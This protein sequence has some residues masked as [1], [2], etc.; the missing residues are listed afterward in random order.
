MNTKKAT[1]LIIMSLFLL[2]TITAISAA[3][4]STQTVTDTASTQDTPT[5]TIDH[6]TSTT[7]S[8]SSSTSNNPDTTSSSTQL[9]TDTHSSD[10]DTS[11][12]Q[13]S[14]TNAKT[15]SDTS[16]TSSNLEKTSSEIDKTITNTPTSNNTDNQISSINNTESSSNNNTQ[17]AS[18]TTTKSEDTISTETS[19]NDVNTINSDVKDT[20]NTITSVSSNIV[21]EKT[22][23]KTAVS[24]DGNTYTVSSYSDLVSAMNTISGL[25][26]GTYTIHFS[27]SSDVTYQIT[28]E[29][30][31]WSSNSGVSLIIDGQDHVTLDGQGKYRFLYSLSSSTI[32]IQNIKFTNCYNSSSSLGGGAILNYGTLTVINCTFTNNYAYREGGAI[33]NRGT[34]TVTNCTFKD[35]EA[36]YGGAIFNYYHVT[37]TITNSTFEG[38]TVGTYSYGGAICNSGGY[39]TIRNCTFKGNDHVI[40]TSSTGITIENCT[41]TDNT[42]HC[43]SD[44]T[45]GDPSTTTI[46]NCTFTGNTGTYILYTYTSTLIIDNS[47]FTNNEVTNGVIYIAQTTEITG[48]NFTENN[49]E[50][51]SAIHIDGYTKTTITSSKFT[52]NTAQN[53]GAIYNRGNSLTL[54]DSTFE[55]NTATENGGAIYNNGS[56]LTVT[57]CNF[58]KNTAQYGGAICNG[59][60]TITNS[61]LKENTAE[62]GGAMYLNGTSDISYTNITE[63]VATE[64][65][66]ALYI[67]GTSYINYTNI[68]ENTA[69]NGGAIY[70]T[71][72]SEIN[73]TNMSKNTAK[74]DGGAIYI[75][76]GDLTIDTCLFESNYATE[77]GGA[78]Y[79]NGKLEVK[80]STFTDNTA[81]KNGGAIY[82]N[83]ESSTITG[84]T[85]TNNLGAEG[86]TIYSTTEADINTNTITRE[87]M[88]RF[89]G[90][91]VTIDSPIIGY[92]IS[93]NDISFTITTPSGLIV[94]SPS[95]RTDAL[96]YT[97]YTLEE[98][99]VYKVNI[100]YKYLENII[101]FEINVPQ[102]V[103]EINPIGTKKPT[104]D[105]TIS[106]TLLYEDEPLI[107][108]IYVDIYVNDEYIDTVKV[109]EDDGTFSYSYKAVEG[110]NIVKV[111]FEGSED[112]PEASD[113][114]EFL[115][116]KDQTTLSL[117]PIEDI[118]FGNE[119]TITFELLNSTEEAITD[120]IFKIEINGEEITETPEY[121]ED[122]GKYV[123]TYT[124]TSVGD[125]TVTVSFDGNAMYESASHESRLF[126]VNAIKTSISI[127]PIDKIYPTDRII[128]SGEVTYTDDD[129]I[130]HEV[131]TGSVSLYVDGEFVS[132]TTVSDVDGSYSFDLQ[133]TIYETT[134]EG[135]IVVKIGSNKI[136]VVYNP[137]ESSGF[138]S[139]TN[140]KN[141]EV[142]KN[143]PNIYAGDHERQDSVYTEEK[144]TGILYDEN[145]EILT[146]KIINYTINGKSDEDYYVI[147]DDVSGEFTIYF[148]DD[149]AET[150]YIL[151]I[152][153][154]DEKYSAA[155]Y[156]IS[157]EFDKIDSEITFDDDQ[158]HETTYGESISIHGDLVDD[159]DHKL[160]NTAVYLTD[161]NGETYYMTYTDE[162]GHYV[163]NYQPT[164]A[165]TITLKLSYDGDDTA[166][167]RAENEI[168]IT[169]YKAT[170][171]LTLDSVNDVKINESI[172][173]TGNL[174]SDSVSLVGE[175]V[176]ITITDEN[177][178]EVET[179]NAI[180]TST[181]FTY[182]TSLKEAGEY[183]VTVY[184]EGNDNYAES[185]KAPGTFEV[186]KLS[187]TIIAQNSYTTTV[188]NTVT[189]TGELVDENDKLLKDVTVNLQ[190][191]NGN[192]IDTSVTVEHGVFTVEYTTTAL[193]EVKLQ[194]VSAENDYYTESETVDVTINVEV[195]NTILT[196]NSID[197]I[198]VGNT[199]TIEGSV[200]GSDG[201]IPVGKHVSIT[202]TTPDGNTITDTAEIQ[203]D[204]SY[205]YNSEALTVTGSYDVSVTF[206]DEDELYTEETVQ[207][208]FVVNKHET[209]IEL[210]TINPLVYGEDVTISGTVY[211]ENNQI[212][213]S[214]SV[215]IV[216]SDGK[217]ETV[218]I[219]DNKFSYTYTPSSI[220]LSTVE[221]TFNDD[222]DY[223]TSSSNQTTF[224]LEK[225]TT[226]IDIKYGDVV[227]NEPVEITATLT[228]A[229]GS[230]IANSEVTIMVNGKEL[231]NVQTDNNG[232][233]TAT[234][235][236]TSQGT[237]T[238]EV[239]YDGNN[240]YYGTTGFDTIE[241]TQK[242]A[243]L[244]VEAEDTTVNKE[245]TI[246][247]KLTT[248]IDG[249]DTAI[250]GETIIVKVNGVEI[251]TTDP[252][253]TNDNGEYSVQYKPTTTGTY[254]IEAIYEGSV[255]YTDSNSENTFTVTDI[256]TEISVT[257]EPAKLNPTDDIKISGEVTYLDD[258]EQK[259]TTG[260]VTLYVDGNEISTIPVSS[261]DGSYEFTFTTTTINA[262]NC[263]QVLIGDNKVQVVYNPA[264]DS[265][266]ASSSNDATFNVDKNQ[267][268]IDISDYSDHEKINENGY[269]NGYLLD[270]SEAGIEGATI[271]WTINGES[272]DSYTTTTTT[273]GEFTI[274]FSDSISEDDII[275]IRY[276]GDEKYSS[277]INYVISHVDKI[278][279]VFDPDS[280][281]KTETS[282][283]SAITISGV[284]KDEYDNLL[285]NTRVTLTDGQTYQIAYTDGNGVYTF[286]YTPTTT[287]DVIL[288]I[289]YAGDENVHEPNSYTLTITVDQAETSIKLDKIENVAIN[290]TLVISGT[291]T[292]GDTIL[293]G[294]TVTVTVK[295]ENGNE[296][297]SK[298]VNVGSDGFTLETVAPENAGTYTVTVT[299]D[300]NDNYKG[301]TE[302]GSLEVTKLS[303][304]ISTQETYTTIAGNTVTIT[305]ELY[306][307]NNNLVVGGTVNL[308]LGD[309]V[310]DSDTTDEHGEFTL[311]YK[312]SSITTET[313][314]I[315][316]IE[317]NNFF[318]TD[319]TI[320]VV[321]EAI[322]TEV[323]IDEISVESKDKVT[324]TGTLTANNEVLNGQTVEIYI[325]DKK[326]DDVTIE[327]GIYT[328]TTNESVFGNNKVEVIFVAT[329]NYAGSSTTD[330][331]TVIDTTAKT[332]SLV[333][334]NSIANITIGETI[335]ITGTLKD[336]NG[337]NIESGTVTVIING[338]SRTT[339]VSN[340]AYKINGYKPQNTGT[341][342]VTVVYNG[343]DIYN[344]STASTKFNVEKL[345]TSVTLDN[346]NNIKINESVT[347]T[348][349]L[350]DNNG[351]L[352]NKEVIITINSETF[353]TRTD[354]N[355]K[356]SLI[357]TPSKTGAYSVL[358][359]YLEIANSTESHVTTAFYTEKLETTITVDNITAKHGETINLTAHVVDENNNPVSEGKVA[360]KLNDVTLKDENGEV[361]YVDVVDGVA[362][363][364]YEITNSAKNYTITGLYYGSDNYY[365][366]KS[367]YAI[368]EV[369]KANMTTTVLVDDITAEYGDTIELVAQIIDEEGN[370]VTTG[371]VVFK[372][373]G[374][375]LKDENGEVIYVDVDEDGY[376]RLEY[377][378]TNN[379]KVYN[380][381]AV[382]SGDG[383]YI[384]SRNTTAKLTV[385]DRVINMTVDS[386]SG[387]SGETVKLKATVTENNSELV[388]EGVVVFKLN[389]VTI[390]DESGESIK[391][392]V[393]NGVAE[394]D[395]EIP[396]DMA[397]KDYTLTAVYSNKNYDRIEVNN[398]LTVKRSKVNTSISPLTTTQGSDTTI[399]AVL[400]DENGNQIER[401]TKVAIKING[402]TVV[403]TTTENGVL[404][405]KIPTDELSKGD[406]TID[407]VFGENSAYDEL[408]LNTTLTIV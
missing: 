176:T 196:I 113:Q 237:Y 103:L 391:V 305:G 9:T 70:I 83:S 110:V 42:N 372:L 258:T 52:D 89:V 131:T 231:D 397:G 387:K 35:N 167:N 274:T 291:L 97:I 197:S 234:F 217:T 384:T 84:N 313:L 22:Q 179:D 328:I 276:D 399:T 53:G 361:I 363:L 251:V 352:A 279:A 320:T 246:T 101:N 309:K 198:T 215:T 401:S 175:S 248:N 82:I 285:T 376:A 67:T 330:H 160:A 157:L 21:D 348:G 292:S 13:S 87:N 181:G 354:E 287:D 333:S 263:L 314:K 25:S 162:N 324:I 315:V 188:G 240:Y 50:S 125:K 171:T 122:I 364:P 289:S 358:V 98:G 20:N 2:T 102:T 241:V 58:T 16:T 144:I 268:K 111:V 165:D 321:T 112:Y 374:V 24:V 64:N 283:G 200:K 32:T 115:G 280:D 260:T 150:D 26:S 71:G 318:S 143:Q 139:S 57:N 124:P 335:D 408:R 366:D 133:S 18:N 327:N 282:V 294:E 91:D 4:N 407:V 288:T 233:F 370:I 177:D 378:I 218:N 153:E 278:E 270:E 59:T 187:T 266:Y 193:G 368:L 43:L 45:T 362:V 307:Q 341:Y 1:L 135:K 36:H 277:A 262:E 195:I 199:V 207:S 396:V 191:E 404:N 310:V 93:E 367:D 69:E 76:N 300:G 33:N 222:N 205:K 296:V 41:F 27:T 212:V 299:Y 48:C 381:T 406:Y 349:V 96:I 337:N 172:I 267:A 223:Y 117:D 46:N 119:V 395:Y 245:T 142:V 331:Y 155:Y 286:S 329:G 272:D 39:A 148:E 60:L 104:E 161:D 202:I 281:Q 134:E 216:I 11:S 293:T 40:F 334:V 56:S 254:T 303:T 147:T 3:D 243:K 392:N 375:S 185:E 389:G 388:N 114:V 405:V 214:G 256:K 382:Y 244:T 225:C 74:A 140:D 92:G 10:T 186:S 174:I 390:R 166:H 37:M 169:V 323:T 168:T 106:G 88:Q 338:N 371:K 229:T 31:R 271:T 81:E 149:I 355:G 350:K 141:L 65:G 242:E 38:N 213:T 151:L 158:E 28:E 85:F 210:D 356:Y 400:Y 221:V 298:D 23:L 146:G 265:S 5:T 126:T 8:E 154:G 30:Y 224:T 99:G 385:T 17:Q 173:I 204:G 130:V 94:L 360:F 206:I 398:T 55:G 66:G 311:T 61:N 322:P 182:S 332:N 252:I 132:T 63:N 369:L 107:G 189:I 255:L 95:S 226:K 184:Y 100:D 239:V 47:R 269:I 73:Y 235:T 79:N 164:T 105:Y 120:A 359:D 203:N 402:K 326:V 180:V 308:I 250:V 77:N 275:I 208:S 78:I 386:A 138:E 346:I 357:Y 80:L 351:V 201:Q 228:N 44:N 379:P 145:D 312:T 249:V 86:E 301:S 194:L 316:F 344:P 339:T 365:T 325:N 232:V 219:K 297:I 178:Q 128:I 118:T 336:V 54:T 156:L 261:D 290:G 342:T 230:N 403:H 264:D 51:G 380:I 15:S 393:T 238:I 137:I 6:T 295:D 347:I 127:D 383:Y 317:N 373:N 284:L 394:L 136:G 75:E 302:P 116:I 220:G 68:T 273:G 62:N 259:V 72:T 152:Y 345:T 123:L 7:S 304:T 90:N 108:D 12:S 170:T 319:A 306:D 190:D 257:V 377:T 247:G 211:D 253:T 353:T 129:N 343:N 49:G 19:D 340:G 34:L 163:F 209:R 109:D 183:T 192:T 14:S 227:I 159:A 29:I 236:P 121:N